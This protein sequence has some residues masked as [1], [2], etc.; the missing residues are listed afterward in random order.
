VEDHYVECVNDAKKTLKHVLA[1]V[2]SLQKMYNADARRGN[3]LQALTHCED[4]INEHSQDQREMLAEVR[5]EL[6]DPYAELEND[7]ITVYT[8]IASTLNDITSNPGDRM[9]PQPCMNNR[10][11]NERSRAC[12]WLGGNCKRVGL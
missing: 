9:P 10:R 1:S 3:L 5:K 8:C 7:V 4:K 6:R 12:N 11:T 2:T